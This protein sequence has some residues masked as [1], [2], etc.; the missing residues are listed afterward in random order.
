MSAALPPDKLVVLYDGVCG[1]CNGFVRFLLAR[2]GADRFRFAPLQSELGR[3]AVRAR[4]GD[5][6]R[7]STIYVIEGAGTE[8]EV[9]R[10]RGRAAIRCVRALGG[11]WRAARIF[12]LVPRVLADLVYRAVAKARYRLFGK[13]E[14]CPLPTP[15]ERGKFLATG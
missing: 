14:S 1:L 10:V 13:H 11:A 6:D 4:G 15:E 7:L 9:V 3:E 5:P 2:D 8:R 12:D